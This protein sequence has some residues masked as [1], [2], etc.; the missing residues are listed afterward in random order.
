MGANINVE[1]GGF[2]CVNG[3]EGQIATF[4]G[5]EE[6]YGADVIATD[7]RGGAAV[8][9]AALGAKGQT[10]ISNLYQLERGY[11]NFVELFRELGADITRVSPK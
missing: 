5:V 6:L 4:H 9:V 10:R 11:G 8:A 3:A 1:D 7:I 2:K